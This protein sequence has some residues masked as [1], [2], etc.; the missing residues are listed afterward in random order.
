MA[1]FELRQS[2]WARTSSHII[3][4]T[5]GMIQGPKDFF[6]ISSAKLWM[7]LFQAPGFFICRFDCC[8]YCKQISGT[9]NLNMVNM[10]ILRTW[11]CETLHIRPLILYDFVV[12]FHHF[13]SKKTLESENI[14]VL[15][16]RCDV[17]PHF[18]IVPWPCNKQR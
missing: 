3:P 11:I 5:K 18:A 6:W 14:S 9:R 16:I 10:A 17:F 13:N 8:V 7:G 2:R 15:V 12:P 1:D 4:M